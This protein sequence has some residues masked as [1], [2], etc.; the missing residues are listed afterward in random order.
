MRPTATTSSKFKV[1]NFTAEAGAAALD[2]AWA[3][4]NDLAPSLFDGGAYTSGNTQSIQL[5]GQ[6]P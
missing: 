3:I 4:L 6:S 5:L 1:D 2:P